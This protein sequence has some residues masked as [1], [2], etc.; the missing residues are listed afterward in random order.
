MF[1]LRPCDGIC[2]NQIG[3]SEG[4]QIIRRK[5]KIPHYVI[6]PKCRCQ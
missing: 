2:K 6:T 5:K 1:D 3:C 4:F